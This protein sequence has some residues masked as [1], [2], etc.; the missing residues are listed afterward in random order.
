MSQEAAG[1]SR[2]PPQAKG[3]DAAEPPAQVL[4]G[5]WMGRVTGQARIAHPGHLGLGL[6]PAGQGQRVWLARSTRSVRVS[7]P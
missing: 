7:K 5:P 1:P 3:Q 2:P 4:G 6:Q